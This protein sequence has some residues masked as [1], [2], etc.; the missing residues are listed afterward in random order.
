MPR[1]SPPPTPAPESIGAVLNEAKR[2]IKKE[3]EAEKEAASGKATLITGAIFFVVFVGGTW[4][5]DM[6]VLA[7]IGMSL[8]WIVG[9]IYSMAKIAMKEDEEKNGKA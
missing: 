8:F 7:K 5:T 4:F 9:I 1:P 2:E 6:S 3:Y